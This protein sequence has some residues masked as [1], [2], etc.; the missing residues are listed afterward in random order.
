MRRQLN[1]ILW[2]LRHKVPWIQVPELYGSR[3]AIYSR[4]VT[5]SDAGVLE[6]I[7][8]ILVHDPSNFFMT[9]DTQLLNAHRQRPFFREHVRLWRLPKLI[10]IS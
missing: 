7:F 5:W 8:D 4:F 1:G 6:S 10:D 9:I 2:V 3:H